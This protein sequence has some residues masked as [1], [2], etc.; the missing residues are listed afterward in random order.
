VRDFRGIAAIVAQSGLN[1]GSPMV[2]A[3]LVD[4]M[5]RTL[6]AIGDAHAVRGESQMAQ[7][8][9]ERLSDEI[10]ELH[11][12]FETSSTQHLIPGEQMQDDRAA[13]AMHE[14]PKS[15]PRHHRRHGPNQARGI[16]R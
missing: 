14:I 10:L 3:M 15:Q 9:G 4:Q 12:R 1:N 13:A 5:G 8:L 6:R 11:E 2:W 7:A 16:E